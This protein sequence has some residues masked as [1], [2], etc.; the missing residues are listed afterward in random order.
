M[1]AP[2]CGG[3]LDETSVRK[4]LGISA[5]HMPDLG[6]PHI[7]LHRSQEA[8]T[9]LADVDTREAHRVSGLIAGAIP[10]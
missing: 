4:E 8:V 5:R 10:T 2:W 3:R 9:L 7:A 1:P 6:P